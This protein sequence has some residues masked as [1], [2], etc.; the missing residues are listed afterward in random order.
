METGEGRARENRILLAV[1][2]AS[3]VAT[4]ILFPA[5]V[6]RTGNGNAHFLWFEAFSLATF[7][8]KLAIFWGLMPT[9]P[10]E[11]WGVALLGIAVDTILATTLALGLGPFLRLPGVGAWLR[12]INQ[13]VFRAVSDYPRLK[14][15]AFW[16]AALFVALPIPG[17]GWMGG[18][19]AGQLLGLTRT[20]GLAAIVVGSTIT[21]LGF[22]GMAQVLGGESQ[23]FL[24]S[25]W[26]S[27]AAT[28]VFAL[29]LWLIWRRLRILLREG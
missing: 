20:L 18:T 10:L 9:S 4:A 12:G 7:P 24:R 23:N 26:I 19:F 28:L 29:V 25:P 13:R 1:W 22:A 5:W 2:V 11:P 17:S 21:S 27:G 16:G 15:M 6:A 3:V 8:G 14:R